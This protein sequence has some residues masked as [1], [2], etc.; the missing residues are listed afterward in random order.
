M[1]NALARGFGKVFV[2]SLLTA[3]CLLSTA[4]WLVARADVPQLLNYQ[5]RLTE[6]DGAPLVGD[7]TVTF[8]IYDAQDQGSKLWEETHQIALAVD[9]T[10]IFS[11]VLG[12]LTPF[13]TLDFNKP[14]WLSLEV[15]GEGEMVPRLRL[16]AVGYAINADTLDGL[17]SAQFLR[18]DA[19]TVATGEL[20]AAKSG[21]AL[22]VQ[23]ATDPAA[24]TKLIDVRNAAGASQFSVD[25]EGDVSLAG[26]LPAHASQHQPGGADALPTASTA[27]VGSVNSEGTSTS[28]SRADHVH[29]GIHALRA[30]GQPQLFGDVTLAAG[31]NVTLSQAGQTITIAA[32]DEDGDGGDHGNT[33]TNFASNSVSISSSS[34]TNLL[35]V[36]ITKSQASSAL[37]L[38]ATV[39]LN[40]TSGGNKT[41]DLKL[42]NGA[43]QLD[44]NYR[45]RI[46]SGGG[47]VQEAPATIH[48]WDTSGAGTYT[49]DLKARASGDGAT[50]T[51][52]RLTV[53]E[54][55]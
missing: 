50:A 47:Q 48:F 54:L 34:D 9:D 49:F 28:L 40:H 38:I 43:N 5:G 27:S 22:V 36:T 30:S 53:V 10:G 41:V 45:A 14:L 37:L 13:A 29:Q 2:L 1:V 31:D 23:P 20:K 12:S 15:D 55:L 44:A 4:Q 42:F 46:G 52:R 21:L 35:S 7:H 6:A 26:S 16:A 24:N 19:D 18:A 11:I 51:V 25:L 8:R 17:T 33:A 39:Q 3:Y 32:E